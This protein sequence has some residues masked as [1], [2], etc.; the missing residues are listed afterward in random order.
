MEPKPG[1]RYYWGPL[2]WKLL[3]LLAEPTHNSE[4]LHIWKIVLHKTALIMPC[5]KCRKHLSEYLL[6]HKLENI[7]TYLWK[8]HNS[9]N[10]RNGM[11]LFPEE[12]LEIY[13]T[14]KTHEERLLE[15]KSLFN[16][17]KAAWTP[18]HHV[19]RYNNVYDEWKTYMSCLQSM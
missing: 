15:T 10:E 14:Y 6:A 9:V 8:L 16:D 1:S 18:L 13:R 2:L 5:E 11:S 19:M 3:H 7:R 4:R 17:I 12:Q